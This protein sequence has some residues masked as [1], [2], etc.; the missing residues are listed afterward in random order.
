MDKFMQTKLEKT[1]REAFRLIGCSIHTRHYSAAGTYACRTNSEIRKKMYIKSRCWALKNPTKVKQYQ[2]RYLAKQKEKMNALKQTNFEEFKEL[3]NKKKQIRRLS[4]DRKRE[5]NFR[6]E[7]P[8]SEN[9]S[10]DVFKAI[11]AIN[12]KSVLSNTD[13]LKICS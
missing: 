1:A 7:N 11:I 9:Y 5:R 6:K 4:E 12:K 2:D 13:I 8:Q 10:K 3:Q